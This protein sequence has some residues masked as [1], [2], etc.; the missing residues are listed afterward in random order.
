MAKKGFRK[1]FLMTVILLAIISTGILTAEA[2]SS[3]SLKGKVP[4]L[5]PSA[6]IINCVPG[7]IVRIDITTTFETT[8]NVIHSHISGGKWLKDEVASSGKNISHYMEFPVPDTF[9]DTSQFKL[10]ISP[11]T[12]KETFFSIEISKSRDT[13]RIERMSDEEKAAE[14]GFLLSNAIRMMEIYQENMT[15][16]RKR[17]ESA[18]TEENKTIAE[19]NRL[20]RELEALVSKYKKTADPAERSAISSEC[21]RIFGLITAEKDR[22]DNLGAAAEAEIRI[23]KGTEIEYHKTK[24]L[25]DHISS[26]LAKGNLKVCIAI[27]NSSKTAANLG[28][29]L[30][31]P[32]IPRN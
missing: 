3:E 7:E 13:K 31:H 9:S 10:Y 6:H 29:N 5:K 26:E 32:P 27:L 11:S 8:A 28:W 1:V 2:D 25:Y 14:V 22:F 21:D 12:K 15:G 19:A 4:L 30:K 23:Y 20:Q 16:I 17:I 18:K 24:K